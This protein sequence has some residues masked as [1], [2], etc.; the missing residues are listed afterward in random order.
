MKILPA[1]I[2]FLAI[3]LSCQS[4]FSQDSSAQIQPLPA[5]QM[6][7]TTIA[8]DPS[9]KIKNVYARKDRYDA[10]S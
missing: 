9:F 10:I 6:R 3:L 4:S 2:F 8:L 7:D 1:F 5:T